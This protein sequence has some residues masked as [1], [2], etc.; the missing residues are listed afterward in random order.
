LILYQK[1][2]GVNFA[3][4]RFEQSADDYHLMLLRAQEKGSASVEGAA[5]NALATTL[6]WSHPMDEMP[7]R[8]EEALRAADR[9]GSPTLRIDTSL[10]I[11]LK[12][13]R[14]GELDEAKSR[15]D[16]IICD[17]RSLGH[18]PGLLGGLTSSATPPSYLGPTRSVS[19]FRG[20][21]RA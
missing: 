6:F 2:G 19:V 16:E 20:P 13:L 7:L 1:R 8:A 18:T 4:S 10:L 14:Y 15:M 5:L 17:S 11:A 12:H 9:A 21:K 3:M